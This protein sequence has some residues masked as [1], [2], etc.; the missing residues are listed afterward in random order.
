MS[1]FSNQFIVE[2]IGFIGRFISH[3]DVWALGPFIMQSL[4]ILLAPAL[5]AASIYIILGRIILLVDGERYSLV[6]QKWLTKLFVAGD[7]FS[8]ML[9]GTGMP[10]TVAVDSF[11][12][13]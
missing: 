10:T 3:D 5:F 13:S 11:V 9:Q 12:D 6:R 8:F 7:I 2:M 4:L 1:S